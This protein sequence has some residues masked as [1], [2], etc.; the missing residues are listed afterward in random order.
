MKAPPLAIERIAK[1]CT[2]CRSPPISATA[3]CQSTC[4]SPPILRDKKERAC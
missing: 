2:L 4:A 3:S 1:M